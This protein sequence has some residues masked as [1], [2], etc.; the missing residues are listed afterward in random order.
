MQTTR[1]RNLR[2]H[3]DGH[4]ATDYQLSVGEVDV[5]VIEYSL[6]RLIGTGNAE[7]SLDHTVL[8]ASPDHRGIGLR[9]EKEGQGPKQDGLTSSGLTGNND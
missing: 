2:I 5:I 3:K 9:A 1:I 4:D 6:Q 7:D 8:G